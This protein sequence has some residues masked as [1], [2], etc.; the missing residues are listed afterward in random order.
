MA[1]ANTRVN[2][3]VMVPLLERDGELAAMARALDRAS[4]GVGVSTAVLG[5]A[6]I[7]KS[8]LLNAARGRAE[9]AGMRVLRARGGELEREFGFGVARQLFEPALLV[10][11][12]AER[13][14]WLDAAAGEAARLVGLAGTAPVPARPAPSDSSFIVLHGLYWLCAQM[15]AA[16]PLCLVVDDA[17][18]ADLASL[19]FFAFLLPRLEELPVSLLLAVR[20]GEE[21]PATALIAALTADPTTE[22]VEPAALSKDAVGRLLHAGTLAGDR[23]FVDRCYRATGG[24]PFLVEQLARRVRDDAVAAP[25]G[26]PEPIES[27]GGPGVARWVRR[28]LTALGPAS[29]RLARAV[30]VFESAQLAQ[31]AAL[32]ELPFP[33]ASSARDA[34]TAADILSPGRPLTF[35]H[36]LVRHAVY[37]DLGDAERSAAHRRAAELLAAAAAPDELVAEH[38]LVTEPAGDPW[39]VDRLVPVAGVAARSGAPESAAAYL[40]RAALEPPPAEQCSGVLLELGSAEF[41]AGQPDALP[42]LEQGVAAAAKGPTRAAAAAALA[43]AL[44]AVRPDRLDDGVHLLDDALSELPVGDPQ[45]RPAE[46]AAASIVLHNPDLAE[47]YRGRIRLER[48]RVDL[49][50]APSGAALALGGY[51]AALG[52]EPIAVAVDLARR[53][54]QTATGALPRPVTM[55]SFSRS[56]VSATLLLCECWDELRQFVDDT[57]AVSWTTGDA[58]RRTN[59]LAH[60]AWMARNLGDLRSAEADALAALDTHGMPVYGFYRVIGLAVAVDALIEQGRLDSAERLLADEVDPAEDRWTTQAFLR[61]NRGRLRAVQGRTAEALTDFLGAGELVRRVGVDS[62]SWV[63]WRSNAALAHLA[64]GDRDRARELADQE[65][66]LARDLGAPRTLGKALHVAGLV[67][68]GDEGELLLREALAALDR[69]GAVVDRAHVL[70]DLGAQLRR[71]NRRSASREYLRQALDI[72]HRAGASPLADRAET[73][74]RTAG[75]RPRRVQLTGTDA[76]TASERR[77]AELAAEGLTNRQ[78]A[79]RQFVTA[80]TVEG[81]L[82][83]VFRKLDLAS[84]EQLA[85]VLGHEG[86]R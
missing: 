64:L 76:L 21:G 43:F 39:V 41:A 67:H 1:T 71:G 22:L 5:P 40:R 57:I 34:L 66:A 81:H 52:N 4:A 13:A 10:A 84:R 6:G 30:A 45:R 44:L 28:R 55:A 80:R 61:V 23:G 29:L 17:Q 73:E 78:I 56:L 31:A 11:S 9:A 25:A 79:Q 69:A 16:G 51:V 42:H 48:R 47:K 46:V 38:L 49:D 63:A 20:T 70:C 2:D 65:L 50:A 62:P 68:G 86:A 14:E 26:A 27:L 83:S 54:L 58:P 7:G 74:L 82:T 12:A 18:W 72:A 60:R 77:V 85:D 59:V 75:A 15:A 35:A 3:A 53:S 24:I 37:D 32:A 33:D 19:R 36:P 8:A